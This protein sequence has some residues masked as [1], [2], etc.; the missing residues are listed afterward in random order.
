[1]GGF[2]FGQK[3][4]IKD[5]KANLLKKNKNGPLIT[6][7]TELIAILFEIIDFF[8]SNRRLYDVLEL[9]LIINVG[10]LWILYF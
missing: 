1:L 10:I 4:T 3:S 5:N 6:I 8:F 7:I 9:M 2:S